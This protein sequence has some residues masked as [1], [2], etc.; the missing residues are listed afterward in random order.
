[1]MAIDNGIDQG[2]KVGIHVLENIETQI[3]NI[4]PKK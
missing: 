4:N 2:E 1:M 3:N